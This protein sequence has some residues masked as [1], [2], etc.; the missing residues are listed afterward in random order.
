[1][2]GRTAQDPTLTPSHWLATPLDAIAQVLISTVDKHSVEGQ[3]SVRLCN[4]TDVYYNDEIVSSDGFMQATASDEQIA[5]FAVCAGDVAITKDS[6]TAA[7]IG[8]AAYVKT[9]LLNT[10]FGYHLATYRP[11]DRRHG[12]YLKWLFDSA[13]MRAT[14]EVRTPGI[15]RVGMGLETLRHTRVLLPPP[16]EAKRIADFL[17]R[18][19]AEIDAFIADQE[20]SSALLQERRS[21]HLI[22]ALAGSIDASEPG[23]A[24]GL[25]WLP[26]VPDHWS[27]GNIRRF[28]AMKTGHTP[29]RSVPEYWTGANIPWFTLADVWQLRGGAKYLGETTHQIS[30]EGLENSA[31]ELLPAGTVVLSRTASVGF[32]GIMSRPMATSQDYWN[33]VP[34]V[35]LVPEFLWYQLQ[36]MRPVLLGLM[37][38]STHKTIY[39]AD[40]AGIRIVVPPV[41]TQ[42]AI[43]ERL[44]AELRIVDE[45]VADVEESITL[46]R[47]RRAALISAAVTG[48]LAVP[49]LVGAESGTS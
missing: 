20:S 16:A 38:G 17:D 39:Q 25:S 46:A 30:G 34:G 37:Q 23:A 26:W 42:R 4:Y 13:W 27:V 6:E 32:S 22:S 40:A 24:T 10:V 14:L 21:S 48:Q 1:M 12:K 29:S 5:K 11:E 43:V 2:I 41:A 31:A 7:D 47:E 49:E 28:A 18:E 8:R 45:S 15:T 19:T 35:R 36:A 9:D 33:W 3:A 44:D